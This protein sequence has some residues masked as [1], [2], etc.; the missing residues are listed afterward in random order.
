MIMI[1]PENNFFTLIVWGL[2][3]GLVGSVMF[4]FMETST[5]IHKINQSKSINPAIFAFSVVRI[6]ISGV[7]MFI[8]F[9]QGFFAGIVFLTG[10][11]ISR[12]LWISLIIRRQQ[13][14][15]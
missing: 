7:L 6:V 5:N 13:L 2:F 14:K 12:W 8:A 9:R 10:F 4:K 11:T 15:G 1:Q 3:G